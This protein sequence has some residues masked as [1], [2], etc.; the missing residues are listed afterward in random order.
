[1]AFNYLLPGNYRLKVIFD[2]NN[3]KNWDTGHY[4]LGIQPEPVYFFP[5]EI[6]IRAN[7]DIMEEWNL[8]INPGI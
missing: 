8:K 1:V 3:N 5:K 4:I 7:W 6:T 2:R